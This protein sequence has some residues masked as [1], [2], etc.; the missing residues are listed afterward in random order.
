M[1]LWN[2]ASK[3]NWDII[4]KIH[5]GLSDKAPFIFEEDEEPP[6]NPTLVAF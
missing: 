4:E 2:T 3:V 1:K 6:V 5:K